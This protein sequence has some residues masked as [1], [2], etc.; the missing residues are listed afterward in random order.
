MALSGAVS[1]NTTADGSGNYSFSGLAVGNYAVAPSNVGYSFNPMSQ[2]VTISNTN[3]SGVNFTATAVPPTYTISGSISPAS[4]GAGSTVTLSGAAT[5]QTTADALGRYSFPGL[6]SG[7]YTV[8]PSSQTAIFS[9]TSQQVIIS[10]SNVPNENFTATATGTVFF[11]DDFTGTTLGADWTAISRHGE[12][13]QSETECNIPGQVSVAKSV[14]TITTAVGPA[15]CGDF[16]I[17]GTVRTP[18]TSWAYITGD[19]QWT[20]LNFTYGTI[21]IRAKFPDSATSLWPATW[22]LGSNCQVT[23]IYTA[24]TGYSTCPGVGLSG[25]TEIDMTECY[26]TGV[27]CQFHVANPDFQIGSGCD[28]VYANNGFPVDT[29]YHVFTTVWTSTSIKQYMDGSLVTTCNQT[30]S[31]PMFLLIQTQT[32]GVGGTPDNTLLPASLQVDYVKV[33]QP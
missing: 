23:N 25:Y 11:F 22:L 15:N 8:T 10:N 6:S 4:S 12:Y 21:E 24:E 33:T 2:P 26:N 1:T 3:V 28:A 14:L 30:L 17:G 27:W 32:G 29:N 31:N 19:I 9:P 18:A 20:S 7:S 5:S 16:N 13:A